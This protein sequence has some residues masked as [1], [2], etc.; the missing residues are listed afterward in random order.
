M[1]RADLKNIAQE[2]LDIVHSGYY[3]IAEKRIDISRMI[4]NCVQNT[5]LYRPD[6]S[7]P[8][9]KTEIEEKIETVIQVKQCSTLEA[10]QYELEQN[11]NISIAALN[12]AS[13]KNP[14]GGFLKG[15]NAQEESIARTSA[16]YECLT[17]PGVEDYYR[18]N[19]RE[20]MCIYTES[21][22]YSP[23][24]PVF[25]SDSTG[26]LLPKPYLCSIITAPAVNYK[27]AMQR[28]NN[29]ETILDKFLNRAERV[30]AVALHNKHDVLVLGAWGCGVFGC[31]L[32]DCSQ[33]FRRLLLIDGARYLNVFKKVVFAIY[34]E[35]SY[36]EFKRGLYLEN[37]PINLG[38]KPVDYC[39]HK[40]DYHGR[41][42]GGPDIRW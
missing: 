13:A 12:F 14:G 6:V 5:V 36:K 31:D 40:R 10:V 19:E 37:I 3:D 22:I 16:L 26:E 23:Q 2:T 32:I 4:Q 30:L 34:D 25:R 8:H 15:S 17:K 35:K 20:R 27:I 1:R 18:D 24:V 38:P 28:L 39:K 42:S 7:I 41:D 11:A 9:N 21:I 33:M 29:R